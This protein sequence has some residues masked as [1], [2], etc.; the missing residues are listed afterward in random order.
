ME[1]NNVEIVPDGCS[2]KGGAC[3]SGTLPPPPLSPRDLKRKW[4]IG[5]GCY[6]N[7]LTLCCTKR[8]SGTAFRWFLMQGIILPTVRCTVA[9][10]ILDAKVGWYDVKILFKFCWDFMTLRIGNGFGG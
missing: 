5:W 6:A 1:L 9:N 2:R 3:S 4:G 8:F 7:G 10:E